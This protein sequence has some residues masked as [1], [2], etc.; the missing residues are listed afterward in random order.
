MSKKIS[1]AGPWIT[2]KEIDYVIDAT[3]IMP[4][5]APSHP[6]ESGLPSKGVIRL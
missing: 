3:K 6:M 5:T 1:F 2:Q 4:L